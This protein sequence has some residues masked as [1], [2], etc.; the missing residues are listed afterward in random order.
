MSGRKVKEERINL[1]GSALLSVDITALPK[2]TYHLL[3]KNKLLN[4]QSKFVK[5]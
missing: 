3:L 1:K 4:E 5:E 2:G